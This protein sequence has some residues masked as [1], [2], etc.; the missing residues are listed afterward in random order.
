MRRAGARWRRGTAAVRGGAGRRQAW[1]REATHQAGRHDGGPAPAPRR[2]PA[3]RRHVRLD[4][5]SQNREASRLQRAAGE[6]RQPQHPAPRRARSRQAAPDRSPTDGEAESAQETRQK[7]RK[8]GGSK[9]TPQ[10]RGHARRQRGAGGGVEAAST[11][12]WSTREAT[13]GPF[14]WA[15]GLAANRD[16]GPS[17]AGCSVGVRS[18]GSCRG[19]R[20]RC[21]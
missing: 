20:V 12:A 2:R 14:R 3:T 8:A 5:A 1:R 19:R 11:P 18:L 10:D 17:A 21:S 6:G 4:A 7:P 13:A 15:T 9:P 16:A